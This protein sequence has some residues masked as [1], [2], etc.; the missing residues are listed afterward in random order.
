MREKVKF[1]DV[2]LNSRLTDTK[3]ECNKNPNVNKQKDNLTH[4]IQSVLRKKTDLFYQTIAIRDS[5]K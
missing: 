4:I 5:P 2:N 1:G 3:M